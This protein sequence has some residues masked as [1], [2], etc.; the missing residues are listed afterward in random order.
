MK[1]RLAATSLFIFTWLCHVEIAAASECVYVDGD[2]IVRIQTLAVPADCSAFVL[3]DIDE[4]QSLSTQN[5]PLLLDQLFDF[6]PDIFA[7]LL[8]IISVSFLTGHGVGRVAR[9]MNKR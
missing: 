8:G 7:Q 1:R 3:I 9:I 2:G 6:D 4:Y 5:L